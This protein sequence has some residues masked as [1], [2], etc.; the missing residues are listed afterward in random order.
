M[1]KKNKTKEELLQ[2]LNTLKTHTAQLQKSNVSIDR[3]EKVLQTISQTTLQSTGEVFFRSIVQNVTEALD[4][5]YVMIGELVGEKK[6]KVKTVAVYFNGNIEENLEYNLANTPSM[7]TI[8]SQLSCYPDSVRNSFPRDELLIK[9]KAESYLGVSLFDSANNPIGILVALDKK[10][11]TNPN[12]AK[13]IF[14]TIAV[15]IA[16]EMERKHIQEKY[17]RLITAIDHAGE[18]I[19]ITDVNGL[20]QYVNPA[21][22]NTTGFTRQEAIG[23]N[24]C[25]LKSGKQDKVFYKKMWDTLSSGKVWYGRLINKKKNGEMWEEEATISPVF[26]LS[27]KIINYVAVKRDVTTV[28]KLERQILQSQKMEAIGTLAGG[29]AHDFNNILTSIIGYTEISIINLTESHETRENLD[30]VLQA[31]FRAKNLTK[32]IL[33]FSR[34]GEQELKPVQLHS[35]IKESL[36]L[37]RATLPSTIDICQD[38]DENAGTVIADPTQICQVILNLCTNAEYAMRNKGGILTVSLKPIEADNNF[39]SSN[40]FDERP[41][42]LI[43]VNDTGYGIDKKTIEHIFDPFFTTKDPGEGTGMGLSIAH[44][45][46]ASHGGIILVHSEPGKGSTFNVY[47]PTIEEEEA[48]GEETTF[49]EAPRGTEKILFVDDEVPLTELGHKMLKS[50]GYEVEI[51]TSSIEAF[52]AFQAMPDKFDLIITDQTMPNMN[53]ETFIKKVLQIRPGMP[54]ILCTGFSHTI[55]AEK[56]KSIGVREYILKPYHIY[57]IAKAIRSALH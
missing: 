8:E 35:T 41:Y 13:W 9:M 33:T 47:L 16:I 23:K 20:M 3:T 54:T 17:S 42:V 24:P 29:I 11:I 6:D 7:S 55:T 12:F 46:V 26:D 14:Q 43:T 52:K 30:Q 22:E 40:W 18:T 27:G 57:D 51:R 5:E 48:A 50:L 31:G 38:I 10:P 25:I 44:G 36:K 49:T 45:I 28:V 39:S 34:H 4:M 32:Q 37:L 2:E 56:A 53:G 21:F 19:M 1:G 15:R